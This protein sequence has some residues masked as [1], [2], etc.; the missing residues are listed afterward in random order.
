MAVSAPFT[1]SP[2]NTT[3]ATLRSA[4]LAHR[5]VTFF[6]RRGKRERV[7][8]LFRALWRRNPEQRVSTSKNTA[9]AKVPSGAALLQNFSLAATPFVALR[10]R[11]RGARQTTKVTFL[12]QA[13][14]QRKALISL[15]N[16]IA[17]GGTASA[18][19]GTRL[20]RQLEGLL[21]PE[22]RPRGV[23]TATTSVG[24]GALR[25]RR[26]EIHRQARRSIPRSPTW[27][28]TNRK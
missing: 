2:V 25:D 13:R 14:G 27:R 10:T 15:A 22:G 21:R 12:P 1:P 18:P 4:A 16:T 7:E 9:I 5:R 20:R 8:G 19:F 11:R 6:I 17:T 23:V 28:G 3:G 26:D 24:V